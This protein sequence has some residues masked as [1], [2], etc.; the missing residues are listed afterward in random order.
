[1]ESKLRTT[2]VLALSLWFAPAVL[3]AHHGSA[4]YD[5]SKRITVQAVVTDWLW[6]NP[7][8]LLEFD[9][10]D[11]KGN[12]VHWNAEVSNPQD[13]TAQGWSRKMFKAGDQVTLTLIPAKNG[14]PIGRIVE[15]VL[16]GKTY[17]GFGARP[18][19]TGSTPP[20]SSKQ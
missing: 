4:L 13:M 20:E 3:L 1:M 14:E 11:D 5:T 12:T 16:N 15:V 10:K 9:V 8:C 18:P 7:H 17:A 2:C 19:A 6:A